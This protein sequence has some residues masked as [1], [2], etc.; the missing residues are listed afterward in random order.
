MGYWYWLFYC[1]ADAHFHLLCRGALG[2]PDC[3][4]YHV[5]HWDP[6][7]LLPVVPIMDVDD[8]VWVCCVMMACFVAV[9]LAAGVI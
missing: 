3:R 4:G 8:I 2:L 7:R 6:A 5:P 9:L 1:V